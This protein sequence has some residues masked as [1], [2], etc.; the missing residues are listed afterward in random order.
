MNFFNMKFKGNYRVER[1][2]TKIT[3]MFGLFFMNQ[4]DMSSE[5]T[6]FCKILRTNF[7]LKDPVGRH[8]VA[9]MLQVSLD[10]NLGFTRK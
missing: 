7:T 6:I 9:M 1:F 5:K 8:V 2:V 4:I 10:L 3:L